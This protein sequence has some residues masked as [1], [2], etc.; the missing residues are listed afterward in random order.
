MGTDVDKVAEI[1]ALVRAGQ[2]RIGLHAIRHMTEEGF[3]EGLLLEAIDGKLRVLE[4]YLAESRYLLLG[5]FQ[6]TT[7][8]SSPLHV[9]CDLSRPGVVGIVTAYVPQRPWWVSP[10]RR[11]R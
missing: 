9:V 10:A 8:A 5:Y 2:Y 4:E 3:D 11:R 7:G 6:F 1:K